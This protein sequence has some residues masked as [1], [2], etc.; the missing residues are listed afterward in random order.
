MF[1]DPKAIARVFDLLELKIPGLR[2]KPARLRVPSVNVVVF[3]MPV[4]SAS[5]SVTVIPVPL[6]PN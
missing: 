2:V 5:A 4:V 3:V 1:P 6:T